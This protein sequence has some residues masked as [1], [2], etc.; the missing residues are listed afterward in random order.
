MIGH[1]ASREVREEEEHRRCSARRAQTALVIC[2]QQQQDMQAQST[3]KSEG[4][5]KLAAAG[6]MQQSE[7]LHKLAAASYI[8]QQQMVDMQRERN[9]ASEAPSKRQGHRQPG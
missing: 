9:T 4:L 7:G 5:H 6:S 8:K 3:S 1:S 2:L